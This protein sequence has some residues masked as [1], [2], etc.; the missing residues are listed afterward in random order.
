MQGILDRSRCRQT[1]LRAT[2]VGRYYDPATAQFLSVDPLVNVTGARYTYA[3]DNPLDGTDPTGLDCTNTDSCP[4]GTTYTDYGGSWNDPSVQSTTSQSGTGQRNNQEMTPTGTIPQ[5]SSTM[6]AKPR[7]VAAV[8]GCP[9]WLTD[10]ANILGFKDIITAIGEFT[11][12]QL[13]AKQ[14]LQAGLIGGEVS[15]GGVLT[16]RAAGE[17]TQLAAR[18]AE[19]GTSKVFGLPA[20][21]MA[22]FVQYGCAGATQVGGGLGEPPPGSTPPAWIQV[23]QYNNG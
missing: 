19:R 8:V 6:P 12:G 14:A 20:G 16:D 7:I 11:Q 15:A 18:L 13:D 23:A 4:K 9:S 21:V 10:I 5:G 3:G 22:T 2:S 17:E 1:T